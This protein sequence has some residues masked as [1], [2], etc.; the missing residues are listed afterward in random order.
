MKILVT[1]GAGFIGSHLSERLLLENN[2]VVIVDNFD[3]FY[4]KSRKLNN[5]QLSL[6]S[7]NCLFIEGDLE[8]KNTFG[9]IPNDIDIV[10]HLA[11]K[12]GVRPSIDNPEAYIKSNFLATHNLL[13]WMKEKAIMKMAFASSSSVYGNNK[14]I[15]FSE[16]DSVDEPISP[17]A[18]TK[19]SCELM[20]HTYHHLY[21]IDIINLRFFT[22]FGERQ[23]PDLAIHKFIKK[24]KNGETIDLY[25]DGQTARDYTY[26]KDTVDGI[27]K[28]IDYLV[29]HSTIFETVNLGR[30]VPI[31]LNELVDTIFD[32]LKMPKKVNYLP[33]QAGDVNITFSDIS[34]AQK[35]FGY[36]PKIGLKEGIE[37]FAKTEDFNS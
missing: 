17:Y 29:N 25:G 3:P 26:V 23:R 21:Q 4:S 35:L 1:G 30:G 10:V 14:I 32:I 8:D 27:V 9:K 11:A 20:N 2:E 37:N 5:L 18:F 19:K 12:A 22:V 6:S 15:P 36:N 13:E 16:K 24:I 28:S 31:K 33:M 7:S 34:K